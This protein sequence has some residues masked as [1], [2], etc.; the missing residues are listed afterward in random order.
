MWNF[1]NMWR[2]FFQDAW[3]PGREKA[4]SYSKVVTTSEWLVV[5][6]RSPS[7]R[8]YIEFRQMK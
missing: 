7:K 1:S 5:L 8:Y 6:K 2:V 4:F 3:R